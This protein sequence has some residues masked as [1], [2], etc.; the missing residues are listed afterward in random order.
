MSFRFSQPK[1]A[2]LH[3]LEDQFFKVSVNRQDHFLL[4]IRSDVSFVGAPEARLVHKNLVAAVTPYQRFRVMIDLRRAK[5]TTSDEVEQAIREVWFPTLMQFSPLAVIVSTAA[6]KL[7]V[8]R[9]FRE[10]DSKG[11]V[12]TSEAEARQ[13]LGLLEHPAP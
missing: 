13:Y 3:V 2:I 7:H 9:M 10:H 8:A 12:F 5:G 6:G 11:K 4:I 1:S